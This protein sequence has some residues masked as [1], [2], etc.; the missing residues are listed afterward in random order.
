M[1]S[2]L[3]HMNKVQPMNNL[4]AIVT[5]KLLFMCMEKLPRVIFIKVSENKAYWSQQINFKKSSGEEEEQE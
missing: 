3:A 1:D 2:E 4:P 5:N